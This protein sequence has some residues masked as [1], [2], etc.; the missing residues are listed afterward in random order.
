MSLNDITKFLFVTPLKLRVVYLIAVH[1][2]YI[3]ITYGIIY[4]SLPQLSKN[5]VCTA[6]IVS[7]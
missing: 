5:R 2:I 7:W 1:N 3:Y 6:T 4:R